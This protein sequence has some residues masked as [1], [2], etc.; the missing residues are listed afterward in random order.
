VVDRRRFSWTCWAPGSG[1]KRSATAWWPHGRW[2]SHHRSTAM[3]LSA[4]V[5]WRDNALGRKHR[6]GARIG[7]RSLRAQ[8]GPGF[9]VVEPVNDPAADLAVLRPRSIR[10]VLFE[11]AA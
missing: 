6:A 2:R 7:G 11:C 10:A 4:E 9:Q 3:R 5:A 1:Q 8:V